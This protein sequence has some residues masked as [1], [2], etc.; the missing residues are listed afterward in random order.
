MNASTHHH[1]AR[2]RRCLRSPPASACTSSACNRGTSAARCRSA[3]A[4]SSQARRQER[5]CC[6]GTTRWCPGRRFDKPGKS[7]FMDMELVPVYADEGADE[8]AVSDQPARAAEPRRAHG[9]SRRRAASAPAC[10][11]VGTVAYNERDS[12]AWCRRAATASSSGCTCARRWTRCERASRCVELYVPDWVAAQEEFLSVR[13]MAAATGIGAACST[14]ARQRMRLA[15]M[16]DEQIRAGRGAAARCSRASRMLAP[17]GGVVAEL[18]AREGMTVAAGRAAVPHQ[19]ARPRS[20]STPRCPKARPRRCGR[21]APSR[22]A[23]PALPGHGVQGQ[24]QRDPARGQC[25]PRARSRRAS[26]SPIPGGALVPGM[27]ATIDF[28]PAARTQV[29][30]VPTEAVIQTGKRSVVMLA[31]KATASSRRSRSRSA[32]EANGQ[33]RDPQGLEAGQKVVVSGQ[34]LIDSEASLKSRRTP[35]GR[36]APTTETKP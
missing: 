27:F 10:E 21:A 26:S 5:R 17:I 36:A 35:H 1:R 4:A 31:R 15:G 9:R 30:L 28:T 8:G 6:T 12:R 7:P 34:F 19:R 29:L 11:A 14:R 18:S 22:R 32:R 23:P 16:S 33:T 13:R 2:R 25:R 20:G 24:G 3:A